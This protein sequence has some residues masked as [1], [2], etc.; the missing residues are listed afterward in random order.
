MCFVFN[1]LV[2]INRMLPKNIATDPKVRIIPM[3]GIEST[4]ESA[5]SC[6][7]VTIAPLSEKASD[8]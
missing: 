8:R 1:S 4:K 6:H 3:I 2:K 7:N 5:N